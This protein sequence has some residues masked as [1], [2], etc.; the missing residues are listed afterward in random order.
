MAPSPL[1]SLAPP[2]NLPCPRPSLLLPHLLPHPLMLQTPTPSSIFTPSA[3]QN[4]VDLS[5]VE[6]I[7]AKMVQENA[8]LLA[9]HAE[10]TAAERRARLRTE[11]VYA[12]RQG[13]KE[14]FSIPLMPYR[15][16]K[17]SRDSPDE[18]SGKT[19]A[20]GLHNGRID[21]SRSQ[22]NAYLCITASMEA[23]DA[24]NRT[25]PSEASSA[26]STRLPSASS[27]NTQSSRQ[28]TSGP[29]TRSRHRQ[30]PKRRQNQP[31]APPM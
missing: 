15:P 7:F 21:F 28:R 23:V 3:G 20:E 22:R 9:R 26:N 12:P 13:L 16:R 17:R 18:K 29:R 11:K 27:I 25:R 30:R 6:T 19:L 31:P 1:I 5:N 8:V 24:S 10:N 4:E 2:P 14:T